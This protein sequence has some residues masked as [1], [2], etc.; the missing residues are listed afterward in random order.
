VK[1]RIRVLDGEWMLREEEQIGRIRN[2]PTALVWDL[3]Q[4]MS[5]LPDGSYTLEYQVLQS[6]VPYGDP[7][8]VPLHYSKRLATG[9][10]PPPAAQ[11]PT[12]MPGPVAHWTFDDCQ[13]TD[14]TGNGHDGTLFGAPECIDGPLPGTRA[15]KF[16]PETLSY[17]LVDRDIEL[18]SDHTLSA[19]VQLEGSEHVSWQFIISRMWRTSALRD[20]AWSLRFS[21][22]RLFFHD[23]YCCVEDDRWAMVT[24][25]YSGTQARVYVDGELVQE[26]DVAPII[27]E[28]DLPICIACSQG[29]SLPPFQYFKG[30]IDE[31]RV[32][33][34]ALSALEIEALY[35]GR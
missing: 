9:Q 34:R 16:T 1:G 35:Q 3:N 2:R 31:I 33:N 32:Y 8:L 19:W 27:Q 17:V 5:R 6:G 20:A 30:A 24:A 18:K 25:T 29:N 11:L 13:P 23:L 14:V 15:L 7:V 28:D 10:P 21:H 22:N 12:A 4:V 26:S